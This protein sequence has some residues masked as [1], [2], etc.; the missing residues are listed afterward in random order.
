MRSSSLSLQLPGCAAD[1][2]QWPYNL[3]EGEVLVGGEDVCQLPDRDIWKIR[4]HIGV[5]FQDFRLLPD[6]TVW[7]NVAF[8]LRVTGASGRQIRRKIP[9][10]LE[11]VGLATRPD[12][13]P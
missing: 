8:A 2:W 4:R 1:L 9:E 10:F 11:L 13:V 6:R 3:T 5:V 7:E 12:A